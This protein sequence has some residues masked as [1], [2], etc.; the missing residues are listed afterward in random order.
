MDHLDPE[1]AKRPGAEIP[2]D[3]PLGFVLDRELSEVHLLLDYL[4][5]CPDRTVP[6]SLTPAQTCCGHKAGEDEDWLVKLCEISWPPQTLDTATFQRAALLIRA[7]DAL[8][9]LAYPASGATIA[10]TMLVAQED[11]S[12]P[13]KRPGAGAPSSR[14]SLS[15]T[16]YPGLISKAKRFRLWNLVISLFISVWLAGTCGLSWYVA[17]GNS[18]LLQYATARTAYAD[19]VQRVDTEEAGGSDRTETPA[20]P[21]H[22]PAAAA[23]ASTPASE[24]VGAAKPGHFVALCDRARLLEPAKIRSGP[25]PVTVYSSV[26]ELQLCREKTEAEKEIIRAGGALAHWRNAPARA[27]DSEL[28]ASAANASASAWASLLGSAVLPV[29]Y[30][31]LGAGALVVRAISRKTSANLLSPRDLPLSLQQL[32]LGAIVGACI[33]L[34]INPQSASAPGAASLLGPV[35]LS[36][37]ALSFIAG[38]GVEGVFRAMEA[39]I[40]RVF[41]GGAGASPPAAPQPARAPGAA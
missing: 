20:P 31:F 24:V 8:N 13:D 39:L 4:S 9:R 18:L 35:A 12:A 38:F 26:N 25:G 10:F 3:N 30:G 19:I 11:N 7:K 33:G 14:N 40:N 23:A 32:A 5:S 1:A 27:V 16:A 15:R 6:R 22:P 17:V 41:G 34:F 29:L 2:T 21:D 36:S 28:K 37:S